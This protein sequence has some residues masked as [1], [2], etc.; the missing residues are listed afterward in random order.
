[1]TPPLPFR[2]PS[3]LG[4][5]DANKVRTENMELRGRLAHAIYCATEAQCL[6]EDLGVGFRP[7]VGCGLSCEFVYKWHPAVWERE[8]GA[9]CR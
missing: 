1:M 8:K 7:L 6:G 5:E 2:R 3:R 4:D 9:V